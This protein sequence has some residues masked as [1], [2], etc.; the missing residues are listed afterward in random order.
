MD[1]RI[2]AAREMAHAALLRLLVRL[3]LAE[4]RSTLRECNWPLSPVSS[5]GRMQPA[6][7]GPKLRAGE[8]ALGLG[9][10]LLEEDARVAGRW[11]PRVQ[12]RACLVE[13]RQRSR[14]QMR[15]HSMSTRWR[16]ARDQTVHQD[17]RVQMR[18]HREAARRPVERGRVV[19]PT[20]RVQ[21]RAH[22]EAVSSAG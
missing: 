12:M 22:R 20:T 3:S 11:E 14:V 2:S 8:Q 16:V 1:S 4:M 15:A 5:P 7:E 19:H 13:G 9:V 6:H 21:M 10:C 18:A 17:T